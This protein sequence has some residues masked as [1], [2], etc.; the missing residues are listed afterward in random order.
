[1]SPQFQQIPGPSSGDRKRRRA[2]IAGCVT[3]A[4]AVL[5]AGTLAF[6]HSNDGQQSGA[7]SKGGSSA[8]PSPTSDPLMSRV[9]LDVSAPKE[10]VEDVEQESRNGEGAWVTPTAYVTGEPYSI[11][12]YDLDSGKPIWTLPLSG[13]SCRASTDATSKG[14]VAVVFAASKKPYTKCTQVAVFDINN[15]RKIWQKEVAPA[16]DAT[17][18]LDLSVAI[19][20]SFV[21]VGWSDDQSH[22]YAVDTGKTV[23]DSPPQG[24]GYE[25]YLGG[26]TVTGLSWCDGEGRYEVTTRDA[27]TG[28]PS[29][30]VQLPDD[31]GYPYLASADPLLVASYVGDQDSQLDANRIWTFNENGSVKTVIKADQYVLGCRSGIGTGCGAFVATED[32]IYIGTRRENLT[33]GND[34]TALDTRTGK[35]KW[36]VDGV[37]SAEWK[38]LRADKNGI[39]VFCHAGSNREGSG[40]FHLAGTDGAQTVLMRQPSDFAISDITAQLA[41]FDMDDPIFYENGRLLF[42]RHYGYW[43][44]GIPMSYVLTIH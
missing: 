40:V 36:T 6:L 42:H 29:R 20:D 11:R 28:E 39:I 19:S 10:D 31:V 12:S 21:A 16:S 32:T 15:G 25:E 43:Q 33:S 13:D 5:A 8:K 22:G 2:V 30:T 35:R 41:P 38:P 3:A 4:L 44:E 23:W 9:L 7:D 24:C 34:M 37:G 26:S 1:M 27:K 14:Y 17:R 18:G